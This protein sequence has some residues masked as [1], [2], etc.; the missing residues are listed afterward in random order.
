[1]SIPLD[2][3]YHYIESVAQDV[4]G[5]TVIYHFYPHGSKKIEDL[6]RLHPSYSELQH[7]LTPLIICNDQEPLNFDFYKNVQLSGGSQFK[8]MVKGPH[9][10]PKMNLRCTPG[11]IYDKCVLLHSEQNSQEVT[12]YKNN[13]FVPVYYWSH[14][15]IALDWYRYAQLHK[16]TK[17][18]RK[19]IRFLI[20][21]RA[22]SGT[23]EYRIKFLELLLTHNITDHCKVTFNTHD[24]EY[25]TYY[26]SYQFNNTVWKS[27]I[28]LDYAFPTTDAT[29]C[30]SADFTINDYQET[31]IE[32][33]LETL[34][35]DSR[36]HL[37]EKTLRPIACCQPFILAGPARS[38][39]YLR[40]YGFKTFN[41]IIDEGYDN[42][43]DAK[44]RLE[45][46]VALLKTITQWTPKERVSNLE[47]MQEIAQWNQQH[48]FSS[49]F[50]DQITNELKSNLSNGINEVIESNTSK[51]YFKIRKQ[52]ATDLIFREYWDELAHQRRQDLE[53]MKILQTILSTARS[54]L[55]N[56]KY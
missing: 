2:R 36:I 28:E 38:L 9:S 34:F 13:D 43:E 23:R 47:K 32:V 4:Y 25:G 29:S 49:K 40:T 54:Y 20:Y 3:L 11:N 6:T 22:W 45:A 35:D 5:D 15:L 27:T 48:F 31:D 37:T 8:E 56:N 41:T 39:E 18:P 21:N 24:P 19:E 26:K 10:L 42:I 52:L 16:F 50:F 7:N 14:A 12:K 53:K 51:N 44:S 46:I 17:F 1:M 33:V 30:F 55:L